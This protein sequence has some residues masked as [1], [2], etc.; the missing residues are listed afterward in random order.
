M[1]NMAGICDSVERDGRTYVIQ[2]EDKGPPTGLI[3]TAVFESGRIVHVR[4][5]SYQARLGTPDFATEKTRMM[6]NQHREV[7]DDVG[8]GRLVGPPAR[9]E[10]DR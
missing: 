8:R 3:E 4:R 10:H 5:V 2:T 1:A 9:G 7:R 6:E